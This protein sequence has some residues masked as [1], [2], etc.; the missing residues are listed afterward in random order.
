[1]SIGIEQSTGYLCV[2]ICFESTVAIE[3]RFYYDNLNIARIE[4][5]KC[6]FVNAFQNE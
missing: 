3:K 4:S 2:Y 5:I 1:M 6:K